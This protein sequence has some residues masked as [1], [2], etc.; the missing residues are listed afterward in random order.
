MIND[1]KISIML[2]DQIRDFIHEGCPILLHENSPLIRCQELHLWTI[3][4]YLAPTDA[5]LLSVKKLL[6]EKIGEKNDS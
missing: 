2:H 5:S 4:K 3:W 6:K 1:E